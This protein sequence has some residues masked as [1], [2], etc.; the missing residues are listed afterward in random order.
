MSRPQVHFGAGKLAILPLLLKAS[1]ARSVLLVSGKSAYLRSGTE[2]VLNSA[3]QGTRVHWFHEFTSNPTIE[4]V[5][6]AVEK[7]R[8]NACDAVVAVGGGTA[9]DIAKAA[10]ALADQ[11]LGALDCLLYERRLRP[12]KR[13]LILAPTTAGTGSEVTR[14]STI[15]VNQ[16]K[17]SLD[18]PALLAD[19][20]IIDPEL[21]IGLPQRIA[22]SAALDAISQAME[23]LWSVGSTESSLCNAREAL[24]LGLKYI[25]KFCMDPDPESR[26]AMARAAL[27]SGYAINVSR[28]TAPHSVSYA[29]TMLFG[30][31][32]GHS[33]ALTLP[34]FMSYNVNVSD[35]DIADPRGVVW[36]QDR[37]HEAVAMLEVNTVD[38]A[39]TKLGRLIAETGLEPHLSDLGIGEN[40]IERVVNFGFDQKR[41]K[42]NP[43]RLSAQGLRDVLRLSLQ[44][45]SRV[46]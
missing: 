14:F 8:E 26:G 30:I 2:Q 3:L 10:A 23:S 4:Q 44:A 5:Q 19:H 31:P 43:R 33:C 37:I 29:L 22:A 12:R 32:H 27:L 17:H 28:T 16:S 35:S 7:S 38:E 42:N 40:D 18:D 1:G 25:R 36:V 9:L 34:G 13:L 46:K 6:A 24:Q 21:T 39:Q 41:A 15:Y 11:K 45:H 20:A